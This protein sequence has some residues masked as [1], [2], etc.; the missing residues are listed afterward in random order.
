MFS[1]PE[2]FIIEDLR[3]IP[4]TFNRVAA[5]A[6][7]NQVVTVTWIG[8]ER[9][10]DIFH[11]YDTHVAPRGNLAVLADA[12]RQRGKWIPVLFDPK[13]AGRSEE[14]GNQIAQKLADL[15]TPLLT[16]ECP[17][18]AAIE[19]MAGRFDATTLRIGSHCAHLLT[20]YR[21]FGR[22]DK[23]EPILT[24]NN[25]IQ[26]TGL[27]V[28][29]GAGIAISEARAESDERGYDPTA[30]AVAAGDVGLTGY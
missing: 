20:E 4:Q 24:G 17:V 6:M 7:D 10:T 18:D 25:L 29:H 8:I 22:D 27:I 5:I 26:G 28:L 13:G 12:I 15:G 19:A 21:R 3:T 9:S 11:V 1:T 23:G 14:E 2:A 16:A 30:D